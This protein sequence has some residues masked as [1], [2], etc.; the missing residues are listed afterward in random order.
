VAPSATRNRRFS[1]YDELFMCGIAGYSLSPRSEVDR[2]RAAQALLAAIAE[3][4][5]D[6]VGYAYRSSSG[7][8]SVHKQRTG[9]SGV[10]E[11]LAI[12]ADAHQA[13]LHVRDYTKGHP[14]VEANNHPVR[15]GTVVG[16]HNGTILND[17]ELMSR[18]GF[19]RAEPA[20]TV[21]SEVIFA[22]AEAT[23]SSAHGFEDFRGSMAAAWLDER[24]PELVY[25]ARGVG[26]PLW[27]GTSRRELFF[28]ST[29]RALEIAEGYTGVRLRKRELAE[30]TLVALA[31][32][33]LVRREQFTPDPTYEADPLPAVRAPHEGAFCL[34]RLAALASA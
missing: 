3:R 28:A 33:R 7:R 11:C 23:G 2:T 25:L 8:L 10:L 29:K 19:Q 5:A 32:P 17:D 26:R 13:L 6:A 34:Q 4:G 30:G 9:A 22:M 24:H 16:I 15:H 18:H 31:G 1:D 20:M 27:V 14:R 12:P 21:D